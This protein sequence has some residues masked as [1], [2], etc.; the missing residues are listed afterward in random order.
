MSP[1][2][3]NL[4]KDLV[5]YITASNCFQNPFILISCLTQHT[6]SSIHFDSEKCSVL[7]SDF[8]FAYRPGFPHVLFLATAIDILSFRFLYLL[9]NVF[10]LNIM[11]AIIVS[12]FPREYFIARRGALFH[13][14][15]RRGVALGEILRAIATLYMNVIDVYEDCVF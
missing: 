9:S 14:N 7:K 6:I 2:T 10:I 4:A 8:V 1:H 3:L 11:P 15:D 13:H 12:H 5:S